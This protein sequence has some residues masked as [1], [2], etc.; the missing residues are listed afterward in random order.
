MNLNKRKI[1]KWLVAVLLLASATL[2]FIWRM[3]PFSPYDMQRSAVVIEHR[4]HYALVSGDSTL[5]Y[6]DGLSHDSLLVNPSDSVSEV[7]R[8]SSGCWVNALPL[9]PSCMGSIATYIEPGDR[10]LDDTAFVHKVVGEELT[11]YENRIAHLKHAKHEVSYYIDTH[12]V[13]DEGFKRVEDFYAQIKKEKERLELIAGMLRKAAAG[14]SVRVRKNE[15]IL[16]HYSDAFGKTVVK[17]CRYITPKKPCDAV[18][19]QLKD[20]ITPDGVKPV[21]TWHLL[22]FGSAAKRDTVFVVGRTYAANE[23]MDYG[24][25]ELIPEYIE[26]DSF[27]MFPRT[28]VSEGSPVFT[29]GGIFIG[30]IGDDKIIRRRQIRKSL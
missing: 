22:P 7:V 13:N 21:A 12:G 5:L 16:V 4:Y 20:S 23:E 29:R 1:I 9:I 27:K 24:D 18:L 15:N 17:E 2:L 26:G 8:Y 14:T 10:R 28:N 6:F 3:L 19:L 30:I 11:N 25:L